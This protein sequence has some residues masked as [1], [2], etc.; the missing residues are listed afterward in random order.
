MRRDEQTKEEDETLKPPQAS[1]GF[2]K[3]GQATQDELLEVNLGPD[4]KPR[5]TFISE[6][7]FS[8]IERYI[9]RIPKVESRYIYM[10]IFG[11]TRS[12]SFHCHTS[13]SN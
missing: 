1:P 9:S 6:N 8:R 5:P 12:G 11:N 7:I 3:G 10:D 4:E 13:P 2:E